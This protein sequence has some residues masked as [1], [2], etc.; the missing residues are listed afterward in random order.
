[1]LMETTVYL[2]SFVSLPGYNLNSG[3]NGFKSNPYQFHI[4]LNASFVD[5]YIRNP[6]TVLSFMPLVTRAIFQISGVLQQLLLTDFIFQQN[7]CH[8]IILGSPYIDKP[9]VFRLRLHPVPVLEPQL[10]FIEQFLRVII[11][12]PRLAVG[13]GHGFQTL[14]MRSCRET[15]KYSDIINLRK[16]TIRLH[17]LHKTAYSLLIDLSFQMRSNQPPGQFVQLFLC[18]DI[19]SRKCEGGEEQSYERK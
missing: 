5:G 13:M 6:G 3:S 2:Y 7:Q 10:Y 4:V 11:F 15:G 19:S 12:V 17:R 14:Q 1:M 16:T 9:P 18:I 8:H